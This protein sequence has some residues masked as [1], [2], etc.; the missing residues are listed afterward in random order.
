MKTSLI[1]QNIQ[2]SSAIIAGVSLLIMA[3][4]AFISYGYVHL[5]LMVSGDPASTVRNI[6]ESF[7]LFQLEIVGWVVIIL[8]DI[9]ISWAFY[10]YLKP[11]HAE[12]SLLAA[13]LRLIYTSILVSAVSNL[14]TASRI[15]QENTFSTEMLASKIMTSIGSFE[16][17]WSIGLIVF[18][19]HL[20]LIG[21]V[22]MKATHIP[23]WISILLIVAGVSYMLIHVL[24][25]FLPQF[26]SVTT[27]LSI[28]MM[29]GEV[30]FGIWLLLKGGKVN[31][32][33][34]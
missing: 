31:P 29:I 25:G 11:V 24:H 33:M 4:A 3:V 27:I 30:G 12:Y 32:Y 9:V 16:S 8:L 5:S 23:K 14:I 19:T 10:V 1:N 22:A 17:I 13:W 20:I 7:S 21:Y 15:L 2:R 34:E 26:D 18:G 6:Q 28:P